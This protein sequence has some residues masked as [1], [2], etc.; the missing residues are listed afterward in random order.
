MAARYAVDAV[1]VSNHGGRQRDTSP[2]SPDALPEIVDALH[3]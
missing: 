2:S 1:W 3:S